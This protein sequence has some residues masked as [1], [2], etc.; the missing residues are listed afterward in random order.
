M[1]TREILLKQL[2]EKR[3]QKPLA[4]VTKEQIDDFLMT[5]FVVHERSC[6][7]ISFPKH[8]E[9][10][11]YD[12]ADGLRIPLNRKDATIKYITDNGFRV[13]WDEKSFLYVYIDEPDTNED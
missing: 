2:A 3:Q 11:R 5:G 1:V 8:L 13:K 9:A 10:S 7:A 4:V 12:E 6:V